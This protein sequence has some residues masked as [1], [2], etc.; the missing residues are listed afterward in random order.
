M[1]KTK[2]ESPN[3]PY[4]QIEPLKKV[5]LS[6]A[7]GTTPENMDLT[8]KPFRFEFIYGISTTGLSPF[9]LLLVDKAPGDRIETGISMKEQKQF[10]GHLA[11]PPI[12]FPS[13]LTVFYLK[14][15]VE[16]VRAASSRE[17]VQE[18]AKIAK[19]GD[20]CCGH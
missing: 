16:K 10:L 6:V 9:E 7:V 8:P 17:V 20:G 14:V 1:V 2:N 18:L 19:C 11:F 3:E 13:D 4:D 15:R 5:V 12:L